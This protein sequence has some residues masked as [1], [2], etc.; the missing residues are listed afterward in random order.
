[1]STKP[2][3]L[4]P[5]AT[6]RMRSWVHMEG[7]SVDGTGGGVEAGR[8]GMGVVGL[9]SIGVVVVGIMGVVGSTTFTA[10][11]LTRLGGSPMATNHD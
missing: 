11:P 2:I 6:I 5:M 9:V 4:L 10:T 1:M 8:E 7:L 3:T